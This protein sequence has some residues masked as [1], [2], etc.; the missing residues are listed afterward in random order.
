MKKTTEDE[1]K[2]ALWGM[3]P[4]VASFEDFEKDHIKTESIAA[5]IIEHAFTSGLIRENSREAFLRFVGLNET[6]ANDS[7]DSDD[8]TFGRLLESVAEKS[9]N[10]L[11]LNLNQTAREFA[12]FGPP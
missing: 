12:N 8:M 10:S 6:D 1:I 4:S 3:F 5:S 2:N 9:V 11:I 7:D